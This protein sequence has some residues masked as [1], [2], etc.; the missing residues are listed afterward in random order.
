MSSSSRA[1]AR[2]LHEFVRGC[3]CDDRRWTA[4]LDPS[5]T[6]AV[7]VRLGAGF[8]VAYSSHAL[9]ADDPPN[10]LRGPL[11]AVRVDVEMG[12]RS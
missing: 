11:D 3:Q 8:R 9:P 10:R 5:A 4:G 7:G 2:P 1:T 12:D 6:R